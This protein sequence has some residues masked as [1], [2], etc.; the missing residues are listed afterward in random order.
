ML[1][2]FKRTYTEG[3]LKI[4]EFLAK[5]QFF[6]HLKYAEMY[7]FLP[8]IHYRKYSKDEVVFFRNDPSQALYIVKGGVVS[9]NVD[10]RENFET[11]Y[12]VRE[13]VAFGENSLLDNAKR[14]YT[15]VV[16]SEEAE[17]MVIPNYA[18]KEIFDSSPKVKAKMLTSLATYYDN[19]NYQLFSSYRK[20][21]GFFNL[22]QMFE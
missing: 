11:I 14:I 7:R 8:A 21:F 12:K 20:S 19:R 17:L 6:N 16:E 13:G 15:A 22:S 18:I 4:F 3:E 1:N 5:T 10:I 9:L 2:P